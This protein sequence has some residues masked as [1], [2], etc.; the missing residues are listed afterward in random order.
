MPGPSEI[1][2]RRIFESADFGEVMTAEVAEQEERLR[3]KLAQR[4]R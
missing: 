2:I 3:D 1:E 4:R